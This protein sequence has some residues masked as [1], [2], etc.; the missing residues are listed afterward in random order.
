MLDHYLRW[1]EYSLEAM[2]YTVANAKTLEG[3]KRVII[4]GMGGS[5]IV[6]DMIASIA[7]ASNHPIPVYVH[8]DFY[9][10][11]CLVDEATFVLSIS[12]SGNTLETV[13]A[14]RKVLQY[15]KS[16]GI[17]ASGGELLK[18][19]EESGAPYIV[20]RGGLA[21]RSALPIM[22]VASLNLLL[23]CRVEVVARDELQR[24]ID[25][26][27]E[28]GKAEKISNE[29]LEFLG[30][31][32]L[33]LIV[34]SQR[35]SAL[36]TRI[37]NELN[38]NSKI[39]AKVEILPE[40]FHNDI[41]GWEGAEFRDR[42]ILIDSDLDYE[43]RLIEFYAE[44]LDSV[45]VNTYLLSL[46]GNVIERLLYGSLIAGITSVKLALLRKL[47]PLQTKSIS[48]YKQLLQEVRKVISDSVHLH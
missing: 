39:P 36:A 24:A 7:A 31:S 22:L 5:G 34:A 37:K 6:G 15:T 45:G 3:I 19:A 17:V 48:M 1:Y 21:P 47:D 35:Y 9:I 38:E 42:A 32:K 13:L 30:S 33:P 43:N 20:V 44:Y 16:V 40:L 28:A 14:T 8:K 11:K 26:L 29:L 25:R 2:N 10:P 23:A 41:V 12:Y 27:R 46:W 4:L 18:I